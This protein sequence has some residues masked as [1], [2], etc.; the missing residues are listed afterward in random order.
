VQP[1][2]ALESDGLITCPTHPYDPRGWDE[3]Y[4]E[5]EP[6]KSSGAESIWVFEHH[7]FDDGYLP[8][9]GPFES[10]PDGIA[11]CLKSIANVATTSANSR[12]RSAEAL[13]NSAWVG[14]EAA[15]GS[16]LVAATLMA[17]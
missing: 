13:T 2:A 6:V 4:F 15:S 5:P 16:R 11:A 9:L 3:L 10:R 14:P 8:A 1:G 17:G 12:S 7:F